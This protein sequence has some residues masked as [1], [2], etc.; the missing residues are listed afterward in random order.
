MRNLEE[1]ERML[2]VFLSR[3]LSEKAAQ[4]ILDCLDHIEEMKN[5]PFQSYVY[6]KEKINEESQKSSKRWQNR[7]G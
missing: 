4:D 5:D 1:D 2:Q 6:T 7:R 3:G